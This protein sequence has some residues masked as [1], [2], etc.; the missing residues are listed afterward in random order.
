MDGNL[1]WVE[2]LFGRAWR[3]LP[4]DLQRPFVWLQHLVWGVLGRIRSPLVWAWDQ[5]TTPLYRNAILIMSTSVIGS[6]LGFFF[7]LVVARFYDKNDV[8]YAI[9]LFQTVSFV[10]SLG[11]LGLGV[12]LVRYLPESDHR[13]PLLNASLTLATVVTLALGV[14]F[15]LGVRIFAPSL[16]FILNSPVYIVAVLATAVSVTAAN[17]LDQ[18]SYAL[19][20]ADAVVWRTTVFSVVKIPLAFVFVLFALTRGRIGVFMAIA[21]AFVAA[22]VLEAFVLLPRILPGFRPRPN[23]DYRPLMPMMRFSAGN[24]ASIVIGNAGALLLPLLILSVLGPVGAENAAFFYIA[25]IVAGLLG[26][27]PSATFTSFYA[28]A[29]QKNESNAQ[30]HL[31]ERRAILLSVLLLIPGIAVLWF[32]SEPM[33]TWFGDPAYASG[34]VGSLHILI[35][36][37]IPTFLNNILGTRVR[38]RR[39]T[40]PLIVGA[41]ITAVVTLALGYTLLASNGIDGLSLAVVLGSAAQTPYMWAVARRPFEREPE[42][43][44]VPVPPGT[45]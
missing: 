3:R 19:R 4:P 42:E 13:A 29:S 18:A 17:H 30:R 15:I 37:S 36:G 28:E 34:A 1:G 2:W 10:A 45:E 41:S 23:L 14:D 43:P 39:K 7:W 16:E 12:A 38:V 9:T 6:G 31:K 8:G 25:T 44:L 22:V 24:Y 32:F 21:I 20:R 35:F 11:F 5:V 27:I 40:R 33:L 26:I